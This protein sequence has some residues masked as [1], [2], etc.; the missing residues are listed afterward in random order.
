MNNIIEIQDETILEQE[1]KEIILEKG[2]RIKVLKESSVSPES[3]N[4]LLDLVD[5]AIK[6]FDEPSGF[7]YSIKDEALSLSKNLIDL[8]LDEEEYM[9]FSDYDEYSIEMNIT[10]DRVMEFL[11]DEYYD[12]SDS[13]LVDW[14]TEEKYRTTSWIE[15][16]S[17]YLRDNNQDIFDFNE[18]GNLA[19]KLA[20]AEAIESVIRQIENSVS[21]IYWE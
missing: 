20:V 8:M 12:L 3:E 4:Q 10:N 13:E 1:E 16:A 5:Q 2:D 19:R 14:F 15:N 18:L 9:D 17:E 21:G 6:N 7:P 11:E